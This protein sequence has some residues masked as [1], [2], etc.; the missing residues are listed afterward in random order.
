MSVE[1]KGRREGRRKGCQTRS[2]GNSCVLATLNTKLT[3]RPPTSSC[4]GHPH[5]QGNT[6][7]HGPQPAFGPLLD[8][9]SLPHKRGPKPIVVRREGTETESRRAGG[10]GASSVGAGGRRG[11]G[12]EGRRERGSGQGLAAHDDVCCRQ[13][14][15]DDALSLPSMSCCS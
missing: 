14:G 8:H 1:K 15:K 4:F 5:S 12:E 2:M 13:A 3:T 9:I 10:V 6:R 7:R 11:G